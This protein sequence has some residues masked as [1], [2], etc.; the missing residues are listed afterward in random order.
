MSAEVIAWAVCLRCSPTWPA[1]HDRD[2]PDC[3]RLFQI[4]GDGCTIDIELPLTR[5]K[6]SGNEDFGL[7]VFR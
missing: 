6:S 4:V 5:S 2:L 3:D 1:L 7:T